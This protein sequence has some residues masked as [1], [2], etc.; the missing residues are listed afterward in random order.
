MVWLCFL[1]GGG[2]CWISATGPKPP[3]TGD[4]AFFWRKDDQHAAGVYKAELLPDDYPSGM[5][6]ICDRDNPQNPLCDWSVVFILYCTVDVHSGSNTARY[7]FPE[8]GEPF[9][10]EHRC[11]DNLQAILPWIRDNVPKPGHLHVSGSSTGAS[12]AATH[13]AALRALSPIARAVFL[14]DHGQGVTTPEFERVRNQNGRYQLPVSVF[15]P[16]ANGTPDT[17]VVAKLAAHFPS[18]RFA[19]FT[20]MHDATQTAFDAQTLSSPACL[21]WTTKMLSELTTRQA[22]PNFRSSVAAG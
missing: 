2:P 1:M 17:K 13:C 11:W 10:I 20:T 5:T 19:Q 12:G 7:T 8:S 4:R 14:G 6:G 3:L 21:T 15:G 22:A 16:D 9:T 18:D